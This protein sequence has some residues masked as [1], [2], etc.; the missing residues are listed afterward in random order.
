M[1]EKVLKV[2]SVVIA[3]FT[4]VVCVSVFFMPQIHEQAVKAAEL[5]ESFVNGN[6]QAEAVNK[7]E[8]KA[9]IVEEEELGGQLRIQMPEGISS[10]KVSIVNDY[11]RQTVFISFKSDEKDYFSNHSIS[12]SSDHIASLFYYKQG[13][14]GVIE[15]GMDRLYEINT[16]FYGD[17]LYLD[18]VNPHDIYD[19]VVVIDA[20]H[21]S[22]AS[23]A[24]KL[25]IEEKNID[26][27]I[28]LQLKKLLDESEE[29]IGVYYTRLED[30][31]P[32]LSQRVEMANKSDADLFISIH[33]NSSQY[34]NFSSLNGTQVLYSE[35][36]TSELSSEKLA[37]ICL[38]NV[39]D[40]LGSRKIGL[41]KADDIYIIRT[42]EV[43]VAL[44]EVGFM[45]NKE[46]LEK[47]NSEEYQKAAAQGI[48]NAI[49]EAF[50]EGF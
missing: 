1:Y 13:D 41:L 14:D 37:K 49:F 35:S 25:N 8:V 21:G 9:D 36:D 20:G 15:L 42:S 46:E 38:D 48:Y 10:D 45:T 5:E 40:A 6:G 31:N 17:S 12:G 22:R 50:K 23:G 33:N 29:N 47:L 3:V 11:V 34:G 7:V 27:Q 19:K 32:T 26:L 24:V 18:F 39:V 28:V 2:I 4:V 30:S 16:D 44:I 43:P